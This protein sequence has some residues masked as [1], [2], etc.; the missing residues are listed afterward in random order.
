MTG[1]L[2]VRAGDVIHMSEQDYCYGFGPLTLRVTAVRG[3]WQRADGP[4]AV[5]DGIPLLGEGREGPERYALIRI[6][7]IRRPPKWGTGP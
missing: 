4:W 7:G 3:T 6:A 1:A 5:V 2:Q